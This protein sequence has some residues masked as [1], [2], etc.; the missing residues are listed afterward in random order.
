MTVLFFYCI[1][2]MFLEKKK[3]IILHLFGYFIVFLK[4]INTK[5][6]KKRF[7]PFFLFRIYQVKNKKLNLEKVNKHYY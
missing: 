7:F 4:K 6:N 3:N 1:F 5:K 2:T